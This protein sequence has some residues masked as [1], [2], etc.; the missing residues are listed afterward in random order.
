MGSDTATA[1]QIT[2]TG[3]SSTVTKTVRST[4]CRATTADRLR[5]SAAGSSGPATRSATG[6]L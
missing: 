5:A 4:S 2:C 6:T 3:W 1:G